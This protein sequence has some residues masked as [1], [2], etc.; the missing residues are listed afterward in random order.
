M[1]L[2][3]WG[4]AT[5]TGGPWGQR[6]QEV[7]RD[8]G[9]DAEWYLLTCSSRSRPSPESGRE[10]ARGDGGAPEPRR[11]PEAHCSRPAPALRGRVLLGPGPSSLPKLVPPG[12]PGTL[13]G[14]RVRVRLRLVR[15]LSLSSSP[16]A[17]LLGGWTVT[18]H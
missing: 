10:K 4:G 12:A 6:P 7:G 14:L 16:R 13:Q 9:E 5:G 17:F 2:S 15:M 3:G 11:P 1:L 18:G 8:A